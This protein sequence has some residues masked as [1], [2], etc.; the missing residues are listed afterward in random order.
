MH[1]FS[2]IVSCVMIFTINLKGG[3]CETSPTQSDQSNQTEE[4]VFIKV[5]GND[6]VCVCTA[7]YDPVCATDG[8]TYSNACALGCTRKANPCKFIIFIAYHH[9]HF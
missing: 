5:D 6:E 7:I 4:E 9:H 8:K 2:V 3:K 1:F